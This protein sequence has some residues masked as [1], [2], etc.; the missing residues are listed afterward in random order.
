MAVDMDSQSAI[1]KDAQRP[2]TKFSEV[3]GAENA[4]T[5]LAWFTEFLKNPKKYSMEGRRLP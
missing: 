2:T 4:K 3:I 1:M 5:E